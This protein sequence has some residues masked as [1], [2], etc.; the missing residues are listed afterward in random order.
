MQF[1]MVPGPAQTV[2]RVHLMALLPVPAVGDGGVVHAGW[3]SRLSLPQVPPVPDARTQIPWRDSPVQYKATD[4]GTAEG[5]G[6]GDT[7]AMTTR[8]KSHTTAAL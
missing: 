2:G 7:M 3:R 8:N 5:R 6:W 4:A 1:K